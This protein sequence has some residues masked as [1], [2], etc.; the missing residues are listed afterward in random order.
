MALGKGLEEHSCGIIEVPAWHL[1]Q[2]MRQVT[3]KNLVRV[4]SVPVEIQCGGI[5]K[6]R[7]L[8]LHHPLSLNRGALTVNRRESAIKATH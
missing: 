6:S 1:C 3:K 7:A 4:A 8:P 5:L 2:E